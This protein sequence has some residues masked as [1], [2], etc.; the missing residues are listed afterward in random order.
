[1]NWYKKILYAQIW[2]TDS[3]DSFEENLKSFYELEY[4]HYSLNT[5]HD[6]YKMY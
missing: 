4:K 3:D 6:K 5:F 2:A 1:M